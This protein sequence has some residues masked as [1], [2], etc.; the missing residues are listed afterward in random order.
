MELDEVRAA[1]DRAYENAPQSPAPRSSQHRQCWSYLYLNGEGIAQDEKYLAALPANEAS[2]T[3]RLEIGLSG[4]LATDQ[5]F[6]R[7]FELAGE[8]VALARACGDGAIL[9][10]ALVR[11]IHS[12]S[13]GES[14]EIAE[15]AYEEAEGILYSF[16]DVATAP[17]VGA[18]GAILH[19]RNDFDGAADATR[20]SAI[21]TGC[22]GT[23]ARSAFGHWRSRNTSTRVAKRSEQ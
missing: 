12:A 3:A 4:L 6:L 23:F 10:H 20:S 2:L 11:Y 8:G 13:A 9:A 21:D 18:G 7:A 22:W 15:R 5:Q 14:L 16:R 17:L 19:A 1:L